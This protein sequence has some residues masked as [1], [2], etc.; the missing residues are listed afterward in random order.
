MARYSVIKDSATA[1]LDLNL[2]RNVIAI[3]V[4][5]DFPWNFEDTLRGT[6][7]YPDVPIETVMIRLL[8]IEPIDTIMLAG[9]GMVAYT[10]TDSSA[11]ISHWGTGEYIVVFDPDTTTSTTAHTPALPNRMELVRAYPNPFNAGVTLSISSPHAAEETI[12]LSDLLGR[13]VQTIPVKLASGATEVQIAGDRFASGV[14]FARLT[15]SGERP[16]RLIHLK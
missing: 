5:F 10:A 2:I 7:T 15:N 12:I 14:Y 8:N 3:D 4:L 9:G 16:V 1:R 11:E 13:T 6:W